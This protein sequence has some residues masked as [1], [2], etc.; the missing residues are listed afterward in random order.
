MEV[1]LALQLDG[2]NDIECSKGLNTP[3]F[4]TGQEV[5]EFLDFNA[6]N[7]TKNL[8]MIYVIFS[9]LFILG[10]LTLEIKVYFKIKR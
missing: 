1:L 6:N 3:C 7:L 4:K 5:L 8:T 10:Y 2:I 9:A